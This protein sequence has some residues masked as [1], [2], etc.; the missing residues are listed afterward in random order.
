MAKKE[1]KLM[2]EGG[3]ASG[4]PPL[5]PALGPMGINTQQVVDEIN[6]QTS[7][8]A[9]LT[10][11]VT[12]VVDASTKEF[13]ISVGAPPVSQLI[14]KKAGIEKGNGKAWKEGE[15][16]S[17]SLADA[18]EIARGNAS[19]LLSL[20]IK[21]ETKEVLGTALSMGVAI[22]GNNPKQAQREI[23]EGKH[24]SAFAS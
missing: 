24:D 12:V 5:G 18:I 23:D 2:V 9:G 3:K 13:S 15:P 6:K 16:S 8:F 4:G 20:D 7:S 11:P 14:K 17:I 10:V 21:A 1:I 22:D 19:K